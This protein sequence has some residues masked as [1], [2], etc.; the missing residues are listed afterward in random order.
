MRRPSECPS[1]CQMQYSLV[2]DTHGFMRLARVNRPSLALPPEVIAEI[3]LICLPNEQFIAPDSTQAL[4]C[5]VL[6]VGSGT[7]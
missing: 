3:F 2:R 4:C 6:Y 7:R 1:D 5:C